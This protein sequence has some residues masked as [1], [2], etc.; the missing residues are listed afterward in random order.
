MTTNL[1][2]ALEYA[3]LGIAIFPCNGKKPITK[4]GF[5]DATAYIEIIKKWWTLHPEANIAIAT[6]KINNIEVLDIDRKHDGF[7]S[8]KQIL[9]KNGPL[10]TN[11]VVK[12]GGGGFHFYFKYSDRS[13]SNRTSILPG[14]DFKTDGGYVIAPP[15]FHENGNQYKWIEF[16]FY[17][18]MNGGEE[19]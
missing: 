15:S 3:S 4:N 6:G 12:T 17:N 9:S 10:P 13:Y 16:N 5:K 7:N 8:L 1:A 11:Y 14:I 19:C 2:K 18:F